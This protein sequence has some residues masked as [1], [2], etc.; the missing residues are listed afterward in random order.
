MRVGDIY[1]VN[2]PPRGGHA[3]AGRRPAIVAQVVEQTPSL[4]TVILIPL[5]TQLDALRFPGTV[6][7][8]PDS[9]NG[10]KRPSVALVFQ[11]AA[12]DRRFLD[13]SVGRIS[14]SAMQSIWEALDKLTGR[15]VAE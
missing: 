3:Q 8:Q 11:I 2:L 14:E 10:L 1:W 12:I 15:S 13:A 4:S 5:T 9:Q 7:I 6:L